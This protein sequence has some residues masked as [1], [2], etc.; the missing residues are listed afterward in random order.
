MTNLVKNEVDHNNN[1]SEVSLHWQENQE[2]KNLLD[3]IVSILAEE[4]IETAKQN[5]EIFTK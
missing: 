4:Y 3:V 1:N 2:V 5:P